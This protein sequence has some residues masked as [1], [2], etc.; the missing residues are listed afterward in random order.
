[1][2]AC[3]TFV[4]IWDETWCPVINRCQWFR[5]ICYLQILGNGRYRCAEGRRETGAAGKMV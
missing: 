3:V 1:M 5:W 2:V 4:V